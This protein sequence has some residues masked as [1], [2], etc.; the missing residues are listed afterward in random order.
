MDDPVQRL[1]ASEFKEV[2][3]NRPLR[4]DQLVRTM[5]KRICYRK[6][7]TV[8]DTANSYYQLT[9]HSGEAEEKRGAVAEPL[10][11][12]RQRTIGPEGNARGRSFTLGARSE[13]R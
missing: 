13:E 4:P 12:K 3:G 7:V 10:H 9:C 5:V 8:I 6:S 11:L 2:L 1:V